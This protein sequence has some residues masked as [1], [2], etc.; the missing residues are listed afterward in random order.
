MKYK[1]LTTKT[2]Q[3]LKALEETLRA[4]IFKLKLQ[5]QVGKLTQVTKITQARRNVARVL[6]ALKASEKVA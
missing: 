4:D 3:E 6:T 1:E 2:P 5:A